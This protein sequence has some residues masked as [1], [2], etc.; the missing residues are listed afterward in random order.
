MLR[1]LSLQ[2]RARVSQYGLAIGTVMVL[3]TWI[4]M[5]AFQ[6]ERNQGLRETEV[7]WP[8]RRSIASEATVP[9]MVSG[10]EQVV[11]AVVRLPHPPVERLPGVLCDPNGNV[12]FGAS[13]A[14][15]G[16]ILA[17]GA[18]SDDTAGQDAGAV[19]IYE[20]IG[21][22]GEWRY[23]ER[24]LA[25]TDQKLVARTLGRRQALFGRR[26]TLANGVLAVMQGSIY[27]GGPTGDLPD[28]V[29]VFRAVELD[30]KARNWQQEARLATPPGAA[31]HGLSIAFVDS[32]TL[33]V[34]APY[35]SPIKDESPQGAIFVYQSQFVSANRFEWVKSGELRPP[36]DARADMQF[37]A[38]LQVDSDLIAVG[39]KNSGGG[40]KGETGRQWTVPLYRRTASEA[41]PEA[42]SFLGGIAAPAEA[43]GDFGAAIALKGNLL[44]VYQGKIPLEGTTRDRTP[45]VF[46]YRAPDGAKSA[47]E[48]KYEGAL[49][50]PAEELETSHRAVLATDGRSVVVGS[51]LAGLPSARS[52]LV[53]LY[54]K[55][56]GQAWQLRQTFAPF[57]PTNSSGFGDA[58]ALEEGLLLVSGADRLFH[59]DHGSV[60]LRRL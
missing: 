20:R 4:A 33:L 26:V 24:I 28:N 32:H 60:F 52:G 25:D 1:A 34:A 7:A 59:P 5:F 21:E 53:F 6:Q 57:D 17:V 55:S 47:A 19:Y 22:T 51:G 44:A 10:L 48:W 43:T 40:T 15:H 16:N 38:S 29:Y 31:G 36:E 50:N 14:V 3:A 58:L 35:A 56:H 37:G 13:I 2:R 46:V 41:P 11:P 9:A 8:P 12:G 27:H 39:M 45:Q 49:P 54:Q 18:A 42:W 30:G 23:R